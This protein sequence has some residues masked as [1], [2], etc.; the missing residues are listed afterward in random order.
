MAESTVHSWI[1][2]YTKKN[3]N[4]L[5]CYTDDTNTIN[6]FLNCYTDDTNTTEKNPCE[7]INLPVGLFQVEDLYIIKLEHTKTQ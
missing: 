1:T 6:I 7:K 3:I 2:R 4:V 5:N